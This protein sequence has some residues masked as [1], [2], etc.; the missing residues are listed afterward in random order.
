MPK[1]L[2]LKNKLNL[3]RTQTLSLLKNVIFFIFHSFHFGCKIAIDNNILHH[4]DINYVN[5]SG[6][7]LLRFL[8][9]RQ[10]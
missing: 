1:T 9:P 3:S 8:M 7:R 10:V 5:G 4:N 6:D 2:E